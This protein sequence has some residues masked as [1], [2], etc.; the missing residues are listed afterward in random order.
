MSAGI[1][2]L[3]GW[4]RE[5]QS[6]CFLDD[7]CLVIPTYQRPEETL[8]LL[9]RLMAVADPPGEVVIVD[10]SADDRTAHGVGNWLQG[11]PHPFDLAYVRSP[12]GLTR[13]RNVGIDASSRRFVFFLD[14]D[15]LPESGYFEAIRRV[16]V[17]D[18]GGAVGAVCGS[19]IN[20]MGRP[21][22]LRWRIRFLLGLV[23]RNGKPGKY[24]PTATSVPISLTAPFAG[25]RAVD[26]LPGG[27]SA[28]R[29]DVFTAARF[30]LFFDGYAQGEDVE[31]SLRIGG[32]WKLLWCGDAHL[33]HYHAPAGRPNAVQKGRMEV[34]NRFFIWKRHTPAAQLRDRLRFWSDIGYIFAYDLAASVVR[35][36]RSWSIRH[37]LGVLRGAAECLTAPPRYEEPPAR[38]EYELVWQTP[39]GRQGLEPR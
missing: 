9:D 37:A 13:Q 33:G 26:I 6:P 30:S 21:T 11:R 1:E 16:F 14:D 35:P 34:R 2:R 24:Y 27:A 28:Y 4:R 38:K 7:C 36:K 10:G 23:P 20:E 12:A 29:R 8:R 22:S 15:C 19:I 18:S 25:V 39:P 3:V 17:E 32:S 5:A 31:M